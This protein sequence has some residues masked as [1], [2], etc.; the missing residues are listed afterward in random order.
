MEEQK[1]PENNTDT[2]PVE[3]P[4]E[5]VTVEPTGETE[6]PITPE[7][8]T[9][10]KGISPLLIGAGVLILAGIVAYVLFG[11][12]GDGLSLTSNDPADNTNM[13]TGEYPD[14][15]A[16]VN[17]ED[18]TAE[19]LQQSIASVQQNALQ[20]GMNP[21]DP[22]AAAQIEEQA[23]TVLLNTTLLVQAAQNADI[24]VSEEQIDEQI[25]QLE[26]QFGSPEA[27]EEQAQ[28]LGMTM[29]D[30]RNDIRE[31]VAVDTLIQ[32]SEEYAAV[33]V[34]TEEVQE[35]YD[36][37]TQQGQE[38]PA[39][40]EVEADIEAQLRAQKEQQAI[41]A[42]IDRLREEAQIEVNI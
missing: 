11:M 28:A 5:P 40:A 19:E 8:E 26:A 18:V 1:N 10:K 32:Q 25:N 33:E 23:L 6:R 36:T 3:T 27:L 15:V 20:Q 38:L 9:A 4:S 41:V 31:Q 12:G 7:T 22:E 14:V 37:L 24:A 16:T 35:V 39:F 2:Q 30:L 34:T 42:L 13:S 17:G 29:E 21:D